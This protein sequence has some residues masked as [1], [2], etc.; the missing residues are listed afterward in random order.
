M[1]DRLGCRVSHRR[2]VPVALKVH[3]CAKSPVGGNESFPK[4]EDGHHPK[5]REHAPSFPMKLLKGQMASKFRSSQAQR[6]R[7]NHI[8]TISKMKNESS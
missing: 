8:D 7:H 4:G 3:L 5:R 2:A 6:G 1:D